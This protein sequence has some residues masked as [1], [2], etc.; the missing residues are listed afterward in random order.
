M[1][2][3]LLSQLE[4]VLQALDN[5]AASALENEIRSM[6]SG[7]LKRLVDFDVVFCFV[8]AVQLFEITN[9]LSTRLQSKAMTMH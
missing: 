4:D 5:T 2:D 9:R 1:L 7:L 3:G 8:V 6:A